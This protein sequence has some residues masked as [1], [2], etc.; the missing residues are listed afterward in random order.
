MDYLW[1]VTEIL[2]SDVP[3]RATQERAMRGACASAL[4]SMAHRPF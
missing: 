3:L 1:Q 4:G 2:R